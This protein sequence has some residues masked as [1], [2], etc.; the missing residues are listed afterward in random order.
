[1]LETNFSVDTF[2]RFFRWIVH[3]QESTNWPTNEIS[4]SD[5]EFCC[6]P[7]CSACGS[8]FFWPCV[9]LLLLKYFNK[10]RWEIKR[11]RQSEIWN[12]GRWRSKC[13]WWWHF[14]IALISA[15]NASQSIETK[16]HSLF[17]NQTIE[18]N[19][20]FNMLS[21]NWIVDHRTESATI[22]HKTTDRPTDAKHSFNLHWQWHSIEHFEVDGSYGFA[23][24]LSMIL[25]SYRKHRRLSQN[26]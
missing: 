20:A 3:L 16:S 25:A 13:S 9:L 4:Q 17:K 1:M 26:P 11:E 8:F 6:W 12:D 10:L 19:A 5:D 15:F 24:V 21:T 18:F 14:N 2:Y 7:K 22:A 23:Y